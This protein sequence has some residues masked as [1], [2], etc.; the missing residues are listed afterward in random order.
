MIDVTFK[1]PHKHL[2]R[3]ISLLIR[4]TLLYVS[5]SIYIIYI[6]H[7]HR[8]WFHQSIHKSRGKAAVTGD[9]QL[10]PGCIERS[11]PALATREP[12]RN[13]F[14][15]AVLGEGGHQQSWK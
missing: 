15:A 8:F 6:G 4:N 7:R 11:R 10:A 9:S 1:G 12:W 13:S 5:H 3:L 2:V 14:R